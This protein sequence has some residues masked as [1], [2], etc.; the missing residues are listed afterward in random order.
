MI[1]GVN[2]NG[3]TTH[4]SSIIYN[5]STEKKAIEKPFLTYKSNYRERKYCFLI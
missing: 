5:L 2:L 3:L 4:L 1:D